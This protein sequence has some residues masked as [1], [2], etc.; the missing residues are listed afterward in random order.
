MRRHSHEMQSQCEVGHVALTPP[1][2]GVVESRQG[3]SRERSPPTW[4]AALPRQ[5]G[6]PRAAQSLHR[7]HHESPQHTQH[8]RFSPYPVELQQKRV[9]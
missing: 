6:S 3:T 8:I 5:E 4:A 9:S 2:D 1:I 7:N